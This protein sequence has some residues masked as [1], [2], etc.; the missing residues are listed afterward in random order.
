MAGTIYSERFLIATGFETYSAWW[1]PSGKRAVIRSVL[2]GNGQAIASYAWLLVENNALA[3]IN[4]Q[5]IRGYDVLD[6]RVVMYGNEKL[7]VYTS[8]GHLSVAVSGYL[9]DDSTGAA[10]APGETRVIER[11]GPQLLPE[12]LGERL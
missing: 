7:E 3:F 4:F 10:A 1:C 12:A 11:R 6:T 9:F 5:A 8:Q 2:A